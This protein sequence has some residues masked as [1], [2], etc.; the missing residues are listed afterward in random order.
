MAFWE[1]WMGLLRMRQWLHLLPLPIAGYELGESLW[2]NVLSLGRGVSIAFCILAFGY[3]LNAVA[4]REMDLDRRK[5]PLLEIGTAAGQMWLPLSLLL[6]IA[7]TLAASASSWVLACTMISLV[8]G[9]LYSVGPR[10]K[11]V[12]FLG[13]LMNL[14]NFVPLLFVGTTWPTPSPRLIALATSFGAMLLQNQLIHEAGDAPE[15][16]RGG[17]QTTF[18]R[19][20]VRWTAVLAMACGLAVLTTTVWAAHRLDLSAAIALHAVPYVVIFPGFL[21]MQGDDPPRMQA[22]RQAQRWCAA[23]SGALLFFGLR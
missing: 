18:L 1:R 6:G 7:L 17:L 3:L 23:A 11:S 9:C 4:D 2:S 16:R 13:T 22:A 19:A 10:L 5:N 15:D 20:G 14:T 12:P 21:W 8:S